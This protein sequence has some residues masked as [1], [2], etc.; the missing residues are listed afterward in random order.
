[1]TPNTRRLEWLARLA[2]EYRADGVIELVWQGCLTYD[3][4]SYHVRHLAER[5]GLGYLKI[6]TDYSPSDSARLSVRI[7]ALIE[8]LRERKR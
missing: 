1:M 7:E 5:H 2:E 6:V 4:E 3:V 8:T